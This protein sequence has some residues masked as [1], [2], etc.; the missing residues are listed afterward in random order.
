MVMTHISVVTH[1][2]DKDYAQDDKVEPHHDYALPDI[3]RK[4]ITQHK[5]PKEKNHKTKTSTIPTEKIKKKETKPTQ[6]NT[7]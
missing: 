3:L 4:P 6:T 5:L 1:R 7:T 2:T